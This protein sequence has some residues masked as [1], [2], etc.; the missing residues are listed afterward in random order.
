MARVEEIGDP[1][2]VLPRLF[3]LLWS[4]ELVV[5]L[6]VPLHMAAMMSVPAAA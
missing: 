2:A 5:D 6:T 1:I 4:R 3:H